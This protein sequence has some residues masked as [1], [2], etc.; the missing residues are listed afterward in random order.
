M[1]ITPQPRD[2][3][4]LAFAIDRIAQRF[5]NSTIIYGP[6]TPLAPIAQEQA[7]RRMQYPVGVN[8]V[9]QP[10]RDWPNLT[11]FDTQRHLPSQPLLHGLSQ[12]PFP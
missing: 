8:M 4:P 10:R 12:R 3:S 5:T 2:L 7:P 1:A 11:P 9:W 6:N